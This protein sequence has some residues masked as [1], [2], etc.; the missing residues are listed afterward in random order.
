MFSRLKQN[1]NPESACISTI[2]G[3]VC[4]PRVDG[5]NS[6]RH[7]VFWFGTI[8]LRIGT[9]RFQIGTRGISIGT[10]RLSNGTKNQAGTANPNVSNA[11]ASFW[12][13]AN[14]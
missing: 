5:W 11:C 2:R 9:S 4:F 10:K 7:K 1:S 6:A 14:C 3:K 8:K 13:I 12:P